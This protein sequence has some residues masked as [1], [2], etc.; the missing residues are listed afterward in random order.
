M[1]QRNS[2]RLGLLWIVLLAT[3]VLPSSAGAEQYLR[4]SIGQD[5]GYDDNIGLDSADQE[6]GLTARTSIGATLGTRSPRLDLSLTGRF[7]YTANVRTDR[8]DT[9]DEALALDAAHLAGPRTRLGLRGGVRRDTSQEDVLEDTG[10]RRRTNDPRYTFTFTPFAVHQ[11]TRRDNLN[12]SASWRRREDTSE[13]G[14]DFTTLSGNLGWRRSM[15]RRTTFGLELYGNHIEST[16]Q[17]SVLA[18]PRLY[19]G[20]RYEER[21]D[22]SLSLGPSIFRTETDLATGGNV[23]ETD[24]GLTVDGTLSAR[25]APTTTARVALSHYLEPAGTT[26]NVRE[27]SRINLQ[28]RQSLTRRL[29]FDAGG[30]AQRQSSVVA[31]GGVDR[32]FFQA[33]T[34]FSYALTQ[35]LDVGVRYRLRHE[36]EDDDATS[37]AVFMSLSYRLPEYRW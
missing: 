10:E 27:T 14:E 11:L 30:L 16:D 6:G 7:G 31:E 2:R 9:H 36:R 20:Y 26:G 19:L 37:N 5:L 35:Q 22:L 17:Q 32:D 21:I 23:S 3:L 1:R 18:S 33:S 24:Y 4:S 25:L 29:S 12:V 34:G 8:S 15:T 13:T 28:L